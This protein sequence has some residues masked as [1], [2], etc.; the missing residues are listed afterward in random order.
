[1]N[2]DN[3][4]SCI[5]VESLRATPIKPGEPCMHEFADAPERRAIIVDLEEAQAR[6]ES[7]RARLSKMAITERAHKGL[8]RRQS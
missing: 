7:T 4:G 8:S 1:M 3:C 5:E 6:L 2:C